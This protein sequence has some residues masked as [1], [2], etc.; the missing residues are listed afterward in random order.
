MVLYVIGLGLGDEKDITVKGL[1]AVRKCKHVFLEAYTAI[2]G[3]PKENLEA[4]Y[5]CKVIEADRETVEQNA[6][7]ILEHAKDE[8]VAFLVVGDPLCATTHTDLV[9]RAEQ[10]GIPFKVI[11]NASIMNAVAA[12]GLQLYNFGQSVSVPFFTEKWRPDSFYSK[13]KT[14]MASKF[15]TM[16]L[17][18]I[19]VKEQ[20]EE[21]MAK[22]LKIYEP[23]RFMTIKQCIEQLL[24]VEAKRE[25]KVVS[26]DTLAIGMARVGQESQQIVSGT[27]KEL[28][29]VDFG[30]PLHTLVIPGDEL[31]FI[32]E[33]MFDFYHWNREQRKKEK[34]EKA[35][36]A[37][38]DRR[39]AYEAERK[40]RA[41]AR[42]AQ[43][44]A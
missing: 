4:F 25:E 33:D 40:A 14:N 41:E 15:H 29:D 32:E 17:L 34:E 20:S 3:A 24:E 1:E 6:N 43:S 30:G 2:L 39:A 5:G 37:E 21:N 13:I 26:E 28:L 44:S 9:L 35:A 36:K 8:D 18:D 16:C 10:R 27:L 12:C 7:M 42:K 22:G 19:K 23:P 38:A 11:H 31:H